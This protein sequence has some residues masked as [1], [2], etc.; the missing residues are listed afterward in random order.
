LARAHQ[1]ANDIGNRRTLWKI[2]AAQAELA[3]EPAQAEK[4]LSQARQVLTFIAENAGSPDRRQSF[5]RL[6]AV[7]KVMQ[8]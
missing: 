6:P 5:L 4:L 1:E 2:L 8:L 7:H 3:S